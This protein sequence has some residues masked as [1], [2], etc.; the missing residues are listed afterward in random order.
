[1]I[2][3]VSLASPVTFTPPSFTRK[4]GEVR[5]FPPVTLRS[6]KADVQH[7]DHI[8]KCGARIPGCANALTLWEGD[9]YEASKGLTEAQYAARLVALL[10]DDPASVLEGLFPV[11]ASR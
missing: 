5:T 3:E 1:M 11:P 4:T 8:K 9:E 6:F 2:V 10:G 7:F